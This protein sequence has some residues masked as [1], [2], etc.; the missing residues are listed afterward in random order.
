[1]GIAEEKKRKP[2]KKF[3]GEWGVRKD[4]KETESR[5]VLVYRRVY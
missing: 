2:N 5:A 3:D 1:M 4:S